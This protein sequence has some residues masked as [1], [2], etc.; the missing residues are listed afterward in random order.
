MRAG[1][2]EVCLSGHT[3]CYYSLKK[4]TICCLSVERWVK[5]ALCESKKDQGN[6]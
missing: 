1:L 3:S 4:F 2:Y 5:E 6:K